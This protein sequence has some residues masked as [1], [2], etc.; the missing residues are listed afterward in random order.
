MCCG[1]DPNLISL[2]GR[3]TI[4]ICVK[5]PYARDANTN[6]N[7]GLILSP[8]NCK[9]VAARIIT[10]SCEELRHYQLM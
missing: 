9:L 3:Q 1:Y 4:L 6:A 5:K 7:Q 2:L 10:F 8:K